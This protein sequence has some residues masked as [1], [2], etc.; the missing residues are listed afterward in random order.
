M[1]YP[2]SREP[3]LYFGVWSKTNGGHFLY[4]CRGHS[5]YETD[6]S[7]DHKHFDQLFK[8]RTQGDAEIVKIG[9]WTALFIYDQSGDSRPGS[10]SVF[11]VKGD[12]SFG[13]IIAL[14]E[15]FLPAI[16][17]RIHA[18]GPDRKSVV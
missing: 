9:G 15:Q 5:I 12:K 1:R 18:A 8:T 11:F 14:A 16:I 3:I 13:E 2:A 6:L 17:G 10:N 7:F 4:D